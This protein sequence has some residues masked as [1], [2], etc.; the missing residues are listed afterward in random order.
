MRETWNK[1]SA[2]E[3]FGVKLVNVRWSWSGL[4]HDGSVVVLVLWQDGVKGRDGRY[5]YDDTA[6]PDA[7]WRR[8]PGSRER[9]ALLATCRDKLGGRFR[10]VVCRAVDVDQDPRQIAS[11]F[12]QKNVWWEIDTFDQCTGAFSARVVTEA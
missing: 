1:T 2:F 6:E 5:A 4:S 7:K 9:T 8:R 11:C 3:H 10:A 12:P